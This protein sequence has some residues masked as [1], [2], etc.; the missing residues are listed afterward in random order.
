MITAIYGGSFDP[1]HNGHVAVAR[2][3][4]ALPDVKRV[5]IMVS[6]RNPLKAESAAASDSQRL[7]MAHIPF[8]GSENIEVSD[9]E[10]HLPSPSY[11]IDTL[12]TLRKQHPH[13]SFRLI[14]GA[15]NWAEIGK[16]RAADEILRDFG[17]IIHPR[18]GYPAPPGIKG[19]TYLPDAPLLDI[20]SSEIRRL[21]SC[22][23]PAG[24]ML[25]AGVEQYIIRNGLYLRENLHPGC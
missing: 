16:W 19:I 21:L 10:M 17:F 25:P 14:I 15:D 20:S 2:Y 22:G 11:T 4:A 18:P 13:N 8:V 23:K 9:F 24:N 7:E 6:R 5:I 12:R 1:I 3:V